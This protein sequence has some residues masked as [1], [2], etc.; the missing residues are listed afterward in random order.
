M[1]FFHNRPSTTPQLDAKFLG[2][3]A[4]L[5]P[6][7]PARFF[8][9]FLFFGAARLKFR[10]FLSRN[11]AA[12][13]GPLCFTDYIR[14]PFF[15]AEFWD[16]GVAFFFPARAFFSGRC[17][18]FSRCVLLGCAPL[19]CFLFLS[20]RA[21]RLRRRSNNAPM[22]L[23]G[24]VVQS[25]GSLAHGFLNALVS[26]GSSSLLPRGSCVLCCFDVVVHSNAKRF[27]LRPFC[28]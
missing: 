26:S 8:D 23:A 12:Q 15:G 11:F 17:L 24:A 4:F 7:L 18:Y 28:T 5:P 25:A 2:F 19:S 21:A 10:F 14:G 22:L 27:S 3:F 1:I 9:F 16:R 13:S 6:G 20:L